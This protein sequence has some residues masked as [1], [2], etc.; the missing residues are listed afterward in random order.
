MI[1]ALAVDPFSQQIIQSEPCLWNVT[2]TTA[3]IPKAQN[4]QAGITTQ[5]LKP[6]MTGSMQAAIYMGL[7]SP[8]ANSSA[9]VTASCETG[10]CTFPHDGGAAFSTLAMCYS[11]VDISDAISYNASDDYG[12]R[13]AT[14]PSGAQIDSKNLMFAS[15]ENSQAFPDSA[16]SFEALMSRGLDP[17]NNTDDFAVACGMMPC[18]KTFGASVTGSVYQEVELSSTDLVPSSHAGYTLAANQTLRDGAWD[19]CAPTPANTTTNTLRVN[20]TSMGLLSHIAPDDGVEYPV[21]PTIH[22]DG[23]GP[24]ASLWYPADCVWWFGTLPAQATSEFLSGLFGNKTLAT[25]YWS[26]DASS[27]EGDLWLANLYR[28]GTATMDTVGAY[29]DGLVWSMTANVR[30]TAGD[31]GALGAVAGRVQATESCLRVRWAWLSLP[32]SLLGLEVAFLVAV[33]MY[34]RASK[35]WHGDWKGSSLALLFH[36]LEP[37]AVESRRKQEEDAVGAS[38]LGGKNGMFQ[39][40]QGMKVQLGNGEG[41]WHL[42]EVT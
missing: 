10:D 29:L 22:L 41:N 24:G 2:G 4:F 26:R 33:I 21:S 19:T 11:C 7:L 20:T 37:R 38:K 31:G 8:P 28:N 23:L 18:L 27:A 15:M 32:A 1:A 25:P 16:F 9:T 12:A 42:C 40:A 13:P 34:S 6:R 3:Q 17:E 5:S 14:I 30:Q 36:G 39:V 35:E